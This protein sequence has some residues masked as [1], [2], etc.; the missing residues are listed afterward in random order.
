M[1][2]GKSKEAPETCDGAG[3]ARSIQPHGNFC[4]RLARRLGGGLPALLR[5]ADRLRTNVCGSDSKG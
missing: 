5:L 3:S 1:W 2:V 4:A